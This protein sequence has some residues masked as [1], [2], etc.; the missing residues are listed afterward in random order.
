MSPT[1]QIALASAIAAVLSAAV[2]VWA[3]SRAS[4]LT[5]HQIRLANR[6][7]LHQVL[8]EVDRELLNNPSLASMFR[9]RPVGL[10]PA[11]TP[12]D[13]VRQ[14]AYVAMYLNM[15][16]LAHSQ[17]GEISTL[18]KEEAESAAA[19]HAFIADFFHDCERAPLVWSSL[20]RLYYGAF[21]AHID[22]VVQ[23]VSSTEP[24]ERRP[25]DA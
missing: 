24:L 4:R 19:W 13:V 5:D 10:S 2:A 1:D 9:S 6:A 8:L 22:D 14:E 17:F 20:R 11:T 23:R 18:T 16:E 15:F 12:E 7:D 25:S 21:R 3:A